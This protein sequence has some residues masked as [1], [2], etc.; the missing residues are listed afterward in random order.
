ME[1]KEKIYTDRGREREGVRGCERHVFH[2]LKGLNRT[3]RV[4]PDPRALRN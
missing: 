3:T 2:W 4:R 1:R